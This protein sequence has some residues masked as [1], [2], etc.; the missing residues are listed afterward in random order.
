MVNPTTFSLLCRDRDHAAYDVVGAATVAVALL[1]M[2][3]VPKALNSLLHALA[4]FKQADDRITKFHQNA[5]HKQPQSQS[6]A[7]EAA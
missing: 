4:D 1:N 2:D 6:A 3:E 7:K 5:E